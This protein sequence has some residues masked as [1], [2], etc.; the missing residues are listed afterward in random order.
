MIGRVIGDP[1]RP[2]GRALIF[3]CGG[4]FALLAA[5]SDLY[6][7]A[8][9]A[10]RDDFGV[11]SAQTQLTLSAMVSGFA[12]AQLAYGPLSDR[13]GRRPVLLGG[14][15]LFVVASLAAMAA[16]SLE[17][18]VAARFVQ[19]MGA[20]SGPVIGRAIVR[21]LFD[22]VRG[23]RT[24]AQISIII[25]LVPTFAPLVGGYVTVLFGWR[26]TFALLAAVGIAFWIVTWLALAESNRRPDPAATRP[27]QILRNA[28]VI[29]RHPTFVAYAV[30]FM[31]TYTGIFFYLSASSFVLIE[32]LGVRPQDFGVWFMFP[33]FGNLIGAFACSRLT[34]RF[35][36][37]TLLG[38]G[39]AFEVTAGLA[40]LALAL[41]GVAHPLA[42]VAPMFVYLVG[43]AFINPVCLA[44]AVGPFPNV[45]GTASAALGFSQLFVAAILGQLFMR[46]LDGTTLPLAAGIA[47]AACLL[48][49]AYLALVRPLGH[50]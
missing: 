34:R 45:A 50:R 21:D 46:T 26:A 27:L 11:T 43:H 16:P 12:I 28:R 17:A 41:G 18:L 9:P 37:P 47:A 33:V 20:C 24:L 13:F 29:F 49:A 35:S 7:P 19:G 38:V 4:I 31:L 23:A 42:I 39:A 10:L 48:L 2:P 30:V 15:A 22:P 3:Y 14:L 5:S 8:L 6:L 1:A 36:L 40:M 44:A 25:S 32:S